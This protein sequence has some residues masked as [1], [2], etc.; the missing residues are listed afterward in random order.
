MP[1]TSSR[2]IILDPLE[3]GPIL[4]SFS[5]NYNLMFFFRI[6]L[7]SFQITTQKNLSLD[8]SLRRLKRNNG[9]SQH[10][11]RLTS[12]TLRQLCAGWKSITKLMEEIS[13]CLFICFSLQIGGVKRKQWQSN[14]HCQL[15]WDELT[16]EKDWCWWG[17][18]GVQ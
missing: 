2:P 3:T 10:T 17:H 15:R 5:G 7:T 13:I 12:L 8:H 4:K 16:D 6:S 9:L 1:T 11:Y 18:F 14:C